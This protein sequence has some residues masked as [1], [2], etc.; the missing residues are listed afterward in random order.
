MVLIQLGWVASELQGP[1]LYLPNS[2]I[3]KYTQLYLPFYVGHG[4]SSSGPPVYTAL[5][6]LSCLSSTGVFSKIEYVLFSENLKLSRNCAAQD[7]L[8]SCT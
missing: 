5:Y 2:G 4:E 6:Q 7:G 3:S 1:R 8:Q